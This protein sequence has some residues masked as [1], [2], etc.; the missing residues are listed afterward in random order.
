[1]KKHKDAIKNLRLK[2]KG[3]AEVKPKLRAEIHALKFDAEGKRRPETGPQRH[4]MRQSYNEH[5]RPEIRAVL[6]ACGILRGLPYR[7]ME[8]K[9]FTPEYL[10]YSTSVLIGNVHYEIQQA[11]R[12]NAELRAEW[13]EDRVRAIIKDGAAPIALEAA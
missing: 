10:T 2:L 4:S 8:P 12:D 6:L 11:I 3:L 1:M 13:T 9:A 5:T 7:R